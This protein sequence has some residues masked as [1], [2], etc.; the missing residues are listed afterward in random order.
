MKR[1][2]VV[3]AAAVLLALLGAGIAYYLHVKQQARDIKGSSTV[4][5]VTTE[6]AVPPPPEPG[7]AWPTYGHDA[8]RQRF[9]NGVS[10]APPFRREWTFRAQS[11]IEF[12]PVIGYGR[13]FFAN[14]AGVV[15]AIGA[16]NGKRAWEYVSNRCVAAS[17]ALDRHVVYETFL[18][19]PPC[20]RAPSP[21]LTGEVVAFAVGTGRV[22]WR[23]TIGP[24]ES[25]PLVI[26]ATIF[27][28]DWDGRIWALRRLTGKP[29][30]VT[31]LRSQVKSGVAISGNRLYVGDYSGHLYS[32][33]ASSG[34]IVWQAS[35]QPRFGSSGNFYATPTLAY[36]RVYIGATDG[37]M[38]SFGASSGKLRWSVSTGGYVYSSAA[39]WRSRVYAGS[40]SHT[41]F[42]FDAATGN[43]L[44]KFKANGPISGSPTVIAGRVYFATLQGTTYALDAT[45]GAQVWTFPDGKYSPVVADSNRLYLVG[46]ARIYGLVEQRAKTARTLSANSALRALRRA[47]FQELQVVGTSPLAIRVGARPKG[48]VAVEH[49]CHIA[50]RGAKANVRWAGGVLQK[51]CR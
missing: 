21:A 22:L 8:E 42:C 19:A 2:L 12:P 13:L 29:R 7:I 35:V 5:F 50:V 34:R 43:I 46:N 24:S 36:G 6:A 40:Y 32:L 31:K 16:K 23:H 14:N 20:N 41:F 44:W 9:A 33:N 10:L 27:A 38:Y 17:P 48:A 11:L 37:K 1:W 30:W 28:G 47:G 49:V 25:S 45:T 18:N 51:A 39:V 3:A 15:F 26:G 4:E